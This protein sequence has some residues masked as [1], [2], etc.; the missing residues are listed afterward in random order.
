MID[1][2][3]TDATHP[4][5]PSSVSVMGAVI[6]VTNLSLGNRISASNVEIVAR[7]IVNHA[8]R[9]AVATV[10]LILMIGLCVTDAIH[11]APY[12]KNMCPHIF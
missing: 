5:V 8:Q 10:Y 2:C 9:S 1:L 7:P 3:V 11:P 6:R 4:A 12:K